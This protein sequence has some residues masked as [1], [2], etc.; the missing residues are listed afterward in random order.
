MQAQV[1]RC[2]SIVSGILLSAGEARGENSERTSVVAFLDEVVADWRASRGARSFTYENRFGHDLPIVSDSALKQMIHNV[3]DNAL[4]AS[5]HWLMFEVARPRPRAGADVHRRRPRLRAAHAGA[6]RQALPVEQGA[7]GRRA[8]ACSWWSTW[9][10][11]WAAGWRRATS[12]RAGAI[13]T[14]TLPLASIVLEE[15]E[16]ESLDDDDE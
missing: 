12:P 8:R 10:A 13:V 1:Q 4:E 11:R 2:K 5:P 9:R 6:V 14:I 3:L 16:G 15:E 7:P